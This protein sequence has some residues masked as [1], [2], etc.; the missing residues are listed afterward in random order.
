MRPILMTSLTTI[1][2][3]MVMA[4]GVGDGGEMM[5]PLAVVSIGGMIFATALTMFVIPVLYDAFFRKDK[6]RR[7][8]EEATALKVE[9]IDE[10]RAADVKMEVDEEAASKTEEPS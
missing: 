8:N 5:Q 6:L 1:M 10:K 7:P 9:S 3:L 4:L 2:G